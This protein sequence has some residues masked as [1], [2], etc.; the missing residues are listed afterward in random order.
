[1]ASGIELTGID[2]L[3]A[4][5][6]QRGEKAVAR[7]ESRALRLAGEPMVNAMKERAARSKFSHKYHL[8]D[9]IVVS[10][11]RRKDG[12]KYVQIGPNKKVA[13]RAHFIEY[14]TSRHAAEPYIEP[15]FLTSKDDSLRILADEVRKGLKG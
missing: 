8:Q 5:L 14:G 15:G 2:Q 3:I 11:V 4:Q 13:F 9:N 10:G 6:R 7:V 12:I 1:M